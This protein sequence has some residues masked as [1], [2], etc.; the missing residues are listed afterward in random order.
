MSGCPWRNRFRTSKNA[1]RPHVSNK[2]FPSELAERRLLAILAADVVGYSRLVGLDEEGTVER[3]KSLKENIIEPA[4]VSH[5]G[6]LVKTTGDGFLIMFSS[7]V[8]AMRCAIVLQRTISDHE[9]AFQA[10]R[11]LQ[12][13]IGVH[14]GDVLLQ[15]DDIFGDGVNIAARLE[16]LAEPGGILVSQSVREQVESRIEAGFVDLGFQALKNIERPVRAAKVLLHGVTNAPPKIFSRKRFA[17]GAMIM[18]VVAAL[19]GIWWWPQTADRVSSQYTHKG[20]LAVVAVKP[21]VNLSGDQGQDYFSE[22]F[23][24]DVIAALG[25]FRELSVLARSA[26]TSLKGKTLSPGELGKLTGASYLVE[27]SVRRSEQR[28][29]LSVQL[30]E[31]A[32]GT[33]LW[34]EQLDGDPKDAIAVQEE[35]SRRIAGALAARLGKLEQIKSVRR[36]QITLDAYD[37]V[38]RAR[39]LRAQRTRETNVEARRLVEDAIKRDPSNAGAYVEFGFGLRDAIA[40]GWVEDVVAALM[41]TEEAARKAIALDPQSAQAY[42]L[43]GRVLLIT[44]DYDGAGEALQRAI[45][46]NPS[47]SEA[48]AGLGDVLIFSGRVEGAIKSLERALAINPQLT[49]DNFLYLAIAYYLADRY[50]DSLRIAEKAIGESPNLGYLYVIAAISQ[51]QLGRA[52]EAQASVAEARRR[53]PYFDPDSFGKLV[54]DQKLR[55]KLITGMSKAGFN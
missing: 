48:L 45:K 30:S 28:F 50:Q 49:S 20:G 7:A 14:L 17:W 23:T 34:S 41:R 32:G 37:L 15:A 55:D 21:F 35:A 2:E 46:L 13:R 4:I 36:P 8:D 27:G 52:D 6:R 39:A 40:L 31:T 16:G 1:K 12:L 38:L 54:R 10:D 44:H 9:V 43:L 53:L 33:V 51:A 29:R 19:A 22:G 26:V 3:V 47:D 18:I 11:R 5:H 24:E 25:R 42:V